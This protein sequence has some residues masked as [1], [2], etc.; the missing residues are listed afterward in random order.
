MSKVRPLQQPRGWAF[1]T[2]VGI[3]KPLLLA[4]TKRNWIGGEKVPATG[5]CVIAV[6]HISH[7]DPLTLGW[8]LY[9]HGRL[10][11]YM[12]KQA[13]FE[14]PGVG[15]IVKNAR[16]IPVARQSR[17][18]A[19]AFEAACEAALA[20]ECIGVYPEGTITKDPDGWPMRGKTGAARI[21]LTTG[22][23]VIPIGQWGAQEILPAYSAKLRLGKTA[24][25][26]VGD[27]VDL[28]AWAG[29]PITNDVLHQATDAIMDA[30]TAL[31]ADIRGEEPPAQRFDPRVAGVN[32]IGNPKK[33]RKP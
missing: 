26:K 25:Y 19:Q 9:D 31:V 12:A 22:V 4:G 33:K 2:V 10:V 17:D 16:Q 21:A 8:F 1:S 23:P 6:N 5:G 27:P 29:K 24:T 30:I 20:G 18:A 7:I 32:E 14:V 11:R 13:L 28:S 3:V 15:A